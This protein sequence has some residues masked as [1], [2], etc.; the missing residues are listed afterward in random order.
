MLDKAKS[1]RREFFDHVEAGYES[2]FPRSKE[3]FTQHCALFPNK[4]S[5]F[6][7]MIRPFPIH[8]RKSTGPYVESEEGLKLVDMWA[9][10][11]CMSMGHS[12]YLR[13]AV[14]E[15]LDAEFGTQI[16]QPTSLEGLVAEGITKATGYNQLTFSTSGALATMHAV[17]M[18]AMNTKRHKIVR[19]KG[20]W[21]GIQPW[22]IADHAIV[23]DN[24]AG[25][26]PWFFEN[27]ITVPFN[28][29]DRL[30]DTFAQYGDEISC[31]ISELVLSGCGMLMASPEFVSA[32]RKN[33]E[34]YGSLLIFD[35]IITGFRVRHGPMQDE[36]GV[37]AD[38]SVYGKTLGGGMPF[39]CIAANKDIFDRSVKAS[40][41]HRLQTDAGTF[42]SHPSSLA[43]A[44][45][46]LRES[47]TKQD[48]VYPAILEKAKKMRSLVKSL[49]K[50]HS[51]PIELTGESTLDTLPCFPIST[52]NFIRDDQAYH[53]ATPDKQ[54]WSQEICDVELRD[55][56]LKQY[57]SQ[58]GVFSWR[59]LGMTNSSLDSCEFDILEKSYDSFFSD[60]GSIFEAII[61]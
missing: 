33:T 46:F 41:A 32:L 35:E 61:S 56:V 52:L 30:E 10:H 43:A 48:V 53:R 34:D 19:I 7:R 28:D 47:E 13:G 12:P 11:F 17:Q 42:T 3:I 25:I 36:F 15:G 37:K 2:L 22:G 57:M 16:G 54:H 24:C 31:C 50:K 8:I 23:P 45:A 55:V 51:V 39:A 29:V 27:V 18:A 20:G 59:G 4:T 44:L 6:G 5:Q 21:H 40:L 58:N 9:G 49:A 60:L 38:I 14:I 1:V 26:P